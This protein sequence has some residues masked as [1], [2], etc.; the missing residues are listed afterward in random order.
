LASRSR[1]IRR[2]AVADQHRLLEQLLLDVLGQ[3]AHTSM[4][5]PGGT[6]MDVAANRDANSLAR[7]AAD[8][9]ARSFTC[10]KDKVRIVGARGHAVELAG[11]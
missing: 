8:E 4:T 2:V 6:Y 11:H 5:A 1:K 7:Q 3:S 9:S 10:D